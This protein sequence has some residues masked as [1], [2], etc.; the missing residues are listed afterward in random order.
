MNILRYMAVDLRNHS[1]IHKDVDKELQKQIDDAAI[2]YTLRE[3][4]FT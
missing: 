3:K 2:D 4:A 1:L